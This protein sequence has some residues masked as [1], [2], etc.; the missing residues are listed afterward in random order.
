[1]IVINLINV[2]LM[3]ARDTLDVTKHLLTAMIMMSVLPMVVI[4]I[5][6]VL[7]LL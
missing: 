6:D 4:V 5:L 2:I 1:M 3:D 7:I